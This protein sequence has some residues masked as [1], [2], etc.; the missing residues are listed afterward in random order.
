MK[1]QGHGRSDDEHKKDSSATLCYY[2]RRTCA[3]RPAATKLGHSGMFRA[4]E[5]SDESA[6]GNFRAET[7][8]ACKALNL[9]LRTRPQGQGTLTT[10]TTDDT[11]MIRLGLFFLFFFFVLF[12]FIFF[13]LDTPGWK[14]CVSIPQSAPSKL[15]MP[16]PRT[17]RFQ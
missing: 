1:S 3:G 7:D 17:E 5:Y 14:K 11:T 10:T 8:A 6:N 9:D 13:S 15:H 2:S 4:G 16:H 12:S